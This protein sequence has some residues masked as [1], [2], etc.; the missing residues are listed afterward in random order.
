[1]GRRKWEPET[2]ARIVLEGLQGKP[3][4]L[5]C[6]EFGICPSLY[7]KWRDHLLAHSHRLFDDRR[8]TRRE[9]LETENENLKRMVGELTL[10]L[11]RGQGR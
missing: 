7:Y 11:N 5:L 10:A 9:H 4:S 2:K 6:R 3:V 1:M 8:K